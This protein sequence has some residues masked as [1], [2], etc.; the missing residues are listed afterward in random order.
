MIPASG[1]LGPPAAAFVDDVSR[2]LGALAGKEASSFRDAAALEAASLA[3]ALVDADETHTTD[4]LV[5][6]LESFRPL[7][8]ALASATMA[9]L[10][11]GAL[12]RGRAQWLRRPSKLFEALLEGDRR[13]GTRRSHTYVHR[14]LDLAMAVASLDVVTSEAELRAMEEFR[15]RL[16]EAIVAAGLPR[17]G[18]APP[19]G[20]PAPGVTAPGA[21][22]QPPG[23]SPPPAD[24]GRTLDELL[25]DLDE[26]VGLEAV[27]DEV[28]RLAALLQI[29]A[30]RRARGL[31]VVDTTLHLVFTGNP[32]TGKT[33]VARLL[34]AIYHRLGAVSAGQLVETDRSG[35]VA[36]YVGQ[37]ATKTRAVAESAIGG[38][39]LID[40]AHALARGEERD[41]GR[42]AIDALVKVM[43]DHRDDLVVIVAGY[44]QEMQHFLDANP[45]LRSRFPRTIEFA[46]YTD[47]ELVAIFCLLGNAKHYVP[48]DDA[49]AELRRILAATERGTAFGNARFIRNLFESAVATQASRLVRMDEPND[50][51][52]TTIIVADLLRAED[53]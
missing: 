39:L 52:L 40:E 24:G 35:L 37:T 6:Y 18:S 51:Q 44:T 26:L 23:A 3:V 43:E 12:F 38:V 16:T 5:G 30:L 21:A 34:G 15:R 28:H 53:D 2:E 31:P 17:P 50:E 7:V 41:F 9:D 45:G 8:D 32:G 42:E 10:R 46:D 27:K 22:A 19:R 11:G 25:A 49:L 20:A 48:T 4:E 33:T 1:P 36:G 14:A 47:D 13:Q 29:Q